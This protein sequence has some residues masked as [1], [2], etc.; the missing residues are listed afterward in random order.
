MA[1]VNHHADDPLRV[2]QGGPSQNE[3]IVVQ[4][5]EF[6]VKMVDCGADWAESALKTI[7]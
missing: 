3:L 1:C 2:L 6:F 4:V 5:D 7:E